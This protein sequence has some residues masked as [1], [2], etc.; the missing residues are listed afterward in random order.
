MLRCDPRRFQ[1]LVGA[2]PSEVRRVSV[3]RITGMAIGWIGST[4]AFGAVVRKPWTLCGPGIGF[5]LV[6]RSPL[7]CSDG[8]TGTGPFHPIE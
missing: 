5:A 8:Q 7:I 6:P 3:V 1:A 2:D 4:T